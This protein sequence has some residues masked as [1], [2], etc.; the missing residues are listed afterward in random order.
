[1]IHYIKF[2]SVQLNVHIAINTRLDAGVRHS[3]ALW[4]GEKIIKK[5]LK[6]TTFLNL[7]PESLLWLLFNHWC[8]PMT[9]SDISHN[10]ILMSCGCWCC[11]VLTVF[12]VWLGNTQGHV[13]CGPSVG[14]A[15]GDHLQQPAVEHSAHRHMVGFWSEIK[16]E[17][18]INLD[19]VIEL[20]V[21]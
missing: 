5:C 17:K 11:L 19:I 18:K 13:G 21:E 8:L 15:Q 3:M 7:V 2:N 14:P 10:L 1:M 4:L 20:M 9:T 16:Y 12:G 6:K